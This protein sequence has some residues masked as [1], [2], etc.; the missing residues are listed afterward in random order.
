MISLNS[1]NISASISPFGAELKSLTFMGKEL[2]WQG[3]ENFWPQSAPILFPFCGFLKD[4]FFMHQ[5]KKYKVPVHGFASQENFKIDSHSS[6][7]VTFV[8]IQNEETKKLYP[9]DFT[10]SVTYE[11]IEDEVQ[12]S[13]HVK[14]T[15][16]DIILP[17][18]IGWH[19]GFSIPKN[20]FIKMPNADLH[21]RMVNK[22]GLIG[23]IEKYTLKKSTVSLHERTFK[24]GGIVLEKIKSPIELK[25]KDFQIQFNV[26]EFPNLVLWGQAGAD[27]V[28][29][30]PW[31]GMGDTVN[32]SNTFI[33][34]ESLIFLKP[35]Q[36]KALHLSMKIKG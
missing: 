4:G 26:A 2:L 34:K 19:P 25:T 12:V 7:K 9:F 21:R 35:Q 22:E 20:S 1:E 5:N 8:L 36:E 14:N 17:Y 30:E 32:H 24:N 15:S 27:F 16:C 28:C 3:K 31:F 18:S 13:L 11:I 6:S 29:I 33:E 23:G 10:L